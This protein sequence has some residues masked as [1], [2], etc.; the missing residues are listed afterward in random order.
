MPEETDIP[1]VRLETGAVYRDNELQISF[2]CLNGEMDMFGEC[3][4]IDFDGSR[5]WADQSSANYVKLAS[6]LSQ[7]F[8]TPKQN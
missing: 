7:L 3:E 4:V 8:E 1:R 5:G 6:C 2:V